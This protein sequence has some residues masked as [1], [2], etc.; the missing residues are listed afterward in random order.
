[1]GK[2]S[3]D[4]ML[5]LNV[6]RELKAKNLISEDEFNAIDLMNKKSFNSL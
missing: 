2:N 3:V 5:S 6:L 4:Y 1:M